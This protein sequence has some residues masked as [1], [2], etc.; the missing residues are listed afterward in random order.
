MILILREKLTS[1]PFSIVSE[2]S[3]GK[4]DIRKKTSVSSRSFTNSNV[5]IRIVAYVSDTGEYADQLVTTVAGSKQKLFNLTGGR[6]YTFV[7]YSL[8]STTD[9]PA[10]PVANLNQA[11]LS[12]NFDGQEAGTDLLYAINKDV[13][14]S[15]GNT[16][17]NINLKHMFSRVYISVND[18]VS[19]GIPGQS[20]YVK[21]SYPLDNNTT[22]FT[23][24]I[25]KCHTS[26]NLNLNN[27]LLVDGELTE[28]FRFLYYTTP[29]A[30]IINTG[31][32]TNYDS[33]L[34]IPP[35]A[36]V[37]ANALMSNEAGVTQPKETARYVINRGSVGITFAKSE[38]HGAK[39]QWS[40]MTNQTGYYLSQKDD[41]AYTTV[42]WSNILH[43]NASWHSG[44]VDNPTK[45]NSD[46]C[47]PGNRVPSY[48]EY[49]K[50]IDNTKTSP[51]GSLTSGNSN[52]NSGR[53]FYSK[54][55]PDVQLTFPAAGFRALGASIGQILNR[56]SMV[57][58]WATTHRFVGGTTSITEG[59]SAG[60]GYPIRCIKE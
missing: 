42:A 34:I 24:T 54:R 50:L 58:Y 2:L 1:G 56:G 32:E 31:G 59:T 29:Q 3:E 57:N 46:P 8:N 6:K 38:I 30:I 52:Y 44:D 45:T 17:V 49:R 43:N 19:S 14:L 22:G 47:D 41:Q 40:A 5:K 11:K 37:I 28:H 60:L 53:R 35:G 16:S 7:T 12:L 25:T 26:C 51:V 55:S 27:A 21:G 20:G 13:M 18:S 33:Q 9:P 15:G 48:P 4:P 10:V 36:I 39:Y 23:G